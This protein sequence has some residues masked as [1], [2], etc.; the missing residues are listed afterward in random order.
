V[1]EDRH[2]AAASPAPTIVDLG[3]RLR[4]AREAAVDSGVSPML[5]SVSFGPVSGRS[6]LPKLASR[7]NTA[8]RAARAKPLTKRRSAGRPARKGD[9]SRNTAAEML[10][11]RQYSNIDEAGAHHCT[12]RTPEQI[13]L[14]KQGVMQ[15]A[16]DS[17]AASRGDS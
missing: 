11:D 5:R 3:S 16:A 6:A 14:W 7:A 8:P 4:E 13:K 9:K 1:H 10:A 12:E 2:G 15:V 17:S